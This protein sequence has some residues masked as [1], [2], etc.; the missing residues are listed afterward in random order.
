[1]SLTIIAKLWLVCVAISAAFVVGWFMLNRPHSLDYWKAHT[2]E[3]AQQLAWCRQYPGTQDPDCVSAHFA[4]EQL[5]ADR[6]IAA[7][8]AFK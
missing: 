7:A 4:E 6:F 5:Q 3:R 1:M 8:R 2:A